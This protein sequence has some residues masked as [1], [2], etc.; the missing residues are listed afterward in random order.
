MSRGKDGT[1]RI[2]SP[3]AV[4]VPDGPPTRPGELAALWDA[5]ESLRTLLE[6]FGGS[7]SQ[8]EYGPMLVGP[9]G[10]IEYVSPWFEQMVGFP[11]ATLRGAPIGDV[12]A[13]LGLPEVE[14]ETAGTATCTLRAPDGTERVFRHRI[15]P[16]VTPDG[17]FLGTLRSLHDATAVLRYSRE[18]AEKSRELDQARAHLTRAQHLQALGQ[19]AA[20]V[21]HEFGNLLQAVGL[22]AAALRHQGTLPES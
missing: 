16:L 5:F 13:W 4:L 22:Q 18:L 14:S 11:A 6:R 17:R 1:S 10:R 21:A 20:E 15:L 9:D 2:P 7:P 19:L 8:P 12:T 3:G